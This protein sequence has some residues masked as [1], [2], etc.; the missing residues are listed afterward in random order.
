RIS[1]SEFN[2]I[3]RSDAKTPFGHAIWG[4]RIGNRE[5]F[6][7]GWRAGKQDLE[8]ITSDHLDSQ[9]IDEKV[10]PSNVLVYEKNGHQYL[11]SANREVSEV[12]VYAI[13][14]EG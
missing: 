4:G 9:L 5:Y 2:Q 8:L 6:I 11:F 7:F 3:S 14:T 13:D 12:A 1:D 10:G